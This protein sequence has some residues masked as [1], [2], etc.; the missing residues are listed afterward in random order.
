M[1]IDVSA[2]VA[3]EIGPY[4]E[5]LDEAR[6]SGNELEQILIFRDLARAR[7]PREPR[8]PWR[9]IAYLESAMWIFEHG[10][11]ADLPWGTYYR[12]AM[13]LAYT[14]AGRLMDTAA[15]LRVCERALEFSERPEAAGEGVLEL[16]W[17]RRRYEWLRA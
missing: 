10:E 16:E 6:E 9:E 14:Y 4:L 1:V 5:L 11:W 15:G 8:D 12:T 3:E 17:L 2:Y 13:D 7:A